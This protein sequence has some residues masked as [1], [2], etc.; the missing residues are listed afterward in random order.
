MLYDDAPIAHLT[1]SAHSRPKLLVVDSHSA[2]TEAM[3]QEFAVDFQVL[4]ATSGAQAL[5]ICLDTPPDLVLLDAVMPV[6]DGFEVCARI[7]ADPASGH[8]PVILVTGHNDTAQETLA[9]KVGAVDCISR[10]I[11]PALARARIKSHI[12]LKLQTEAMRKLVFRDGLTGAFNR[13][14]FDQQLTMEMA[15]SVR[16]HSPLILIMIQVDFFDRFNVSR[17]H[18]AGD[19]CLRAVVNCLREGL[20][21][22]A[23]LVARIGGDA[24]ACLLPETEFDNAMAIAREL[25]LRVRGKGLAHDQSDAASVVTI[26]LGVAGRTGNTVGAARDLLALASAHLRRAIDAGHGRV[27]GGLL[28]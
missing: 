7:H 23:D 15:R 4:I 20:R 22:P 3:Y 19:D 18:S 26:S 5:S 11:N 21:R 24:F 2:T 8:I 6:M 27:L 10:P 9:L 28:S 1:D 17:G 16:N 14:Y 13:R 12:T 25:E